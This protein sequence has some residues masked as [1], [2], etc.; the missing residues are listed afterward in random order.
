MSTSLMVDALKYVT[1][2]E[3]CSELIKMHKNN[4][5]PDNQYYY[6]IELSIKQGGVYEILTHSYEN[7]RLLF[8]SIKSLIDF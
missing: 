7:L 6:S 8:K 2:S 3:S 5:L 1:I 4:N